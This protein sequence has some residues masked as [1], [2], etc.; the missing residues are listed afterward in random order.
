MTEYINSKGNEVTDNTIVVIP[1]SEYKDYSYTEIIEPLAGKVKRQWFSEHFYYCLPVVIG[2]QYGFAIKSS[3]DFSAIWS[4]V[5]SEE[6]RI[7]SKREDA[8]IQSVDGHFKS[9]VV[10]IQNRF[11]LKT[12]PGIN[13][14]I[15]QPPNFYI[16]GLVSMTAVVETD[17]IRRDFSI[18]L[19]VTMPNIVVSVK[20]GDYL[21]VVIPIQ[22]GTVENY[23]LKHISE[24]YTQEQ[25]IIERGEAKALGDERSG[26]DKLKPHA[27]GRRYFNGQHTNGD[28]YMNH[29][30]TIKKIV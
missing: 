22:R 20:K 1:F 27:A 19:R 25:F 21:S 23:S 12:P 28:K 10:T 4:G 11:A 2:N 26:V 7:F 18:N 15:T 24:I 3:I 6:V 8:D 14:L 9:G 5:D 17:N 16:N 29:Q 13:L 30:K